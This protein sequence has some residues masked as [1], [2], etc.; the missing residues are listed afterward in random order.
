V[1]II[2]G[3]VLTRHPFVPGSVW[4]RLHW[5]VGLRRLGHE[6]FYVEEIAER[7]CLDAV[8]RRCEYRR[9]VNRA[10][11]EQ[12]TRRLGLG[13]RSCQ[14]YEDGEDTCGL[15]VNEISAIAR[16]AGLLINLSGH[17]RSEWIRDQVACRAY[18]DHDPVYTQLWHAEYGSELGFGA[19][20]VFFTVGLNIGTPQSPV[21]DCG[22][23]WKPL[24]QPVVPDLWPAAKPKA[25]TRFSTVASWSG[26]G[27]VALDGSWYRGRHQEFERFASL[28]KLSGQECEL[29]LSGHRR[30]DPGVARLRRNGWLVSDA[31]R[32]RTLDEYQRFISGSR[33]EIGVAKNAYVRG[34]SG[35]FSDRSAHYLTSGRPVLHQSTGFESR[36][37][38][39]RGLLTFTTLDEAVE[40]IRE[41]NSDHRGHSHAAREFASEFLDYRRVLPQMLESLSDGG[42]G[43]PASAAEERR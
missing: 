2:I 14:V 8:G 7:D 42:R 10:L 29:A 32:I 35:W 1:K 22:I 11:F 15:S 16:E 3:A 40:G 5:A 20:D 23:E 21:P 24:L 18:V 6:V 17:V 9:S 41:V 30:D 27:D 13:G 25:N 36:L 39:G 19:H 28:P 38:T 12:T 33:G 34:R 43:R 37:P 4:T 26:Y 31:T